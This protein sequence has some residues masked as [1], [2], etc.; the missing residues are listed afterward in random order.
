MVFLPLKLVLKRLENEEAELR[1]LGYEFTA[2]ELHDGSD[3][4]TIELLTINGRERLNVIKRYRV[5]INARG[6][7]RR[8]TGE[9]VPRFRHEVYIYILR[10]YP[11]VDTRRYGAPV[12]FQWI[13]PIF[14]PNISNGI[15]AGGL[16]IVC[17]HIL[18]EWI[19]SFT[20]PKIVEALKSLVENPNPDDALIYPETLEAARWFARR[21]PS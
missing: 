8:P 1:S 14:H 21:R 7:E 17:W 16:G 19:P 6:Y 20:L 12:R 4:K 2:E 18:K 15:E 5:T 10:H 3:G 13:T 11:F 9:I